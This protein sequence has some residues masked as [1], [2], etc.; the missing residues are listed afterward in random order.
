MRSIHRTLGV[1][2]ARSHRSVRQRTNWM[3]Q[4]SELPLSEALTPRESDQVQRA[5]TIADDLGD[6]QHR[7]REDRTGNTRDDN[8]DGIEDEPSG[9]KHRGQRLALDQMKSNARN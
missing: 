2:L 6:G 7:Q 4:I 8:E 1:T 3:T 5:N 9:Q